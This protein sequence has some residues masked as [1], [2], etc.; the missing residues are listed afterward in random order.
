MDMSENK[1]PR[2]GAIGILGGGQLGRMLCVAAAQLG[3]RT[4]IFAPTTPCPAGDV[5]TRTIEGEYD[6]HDALSEFVSCTDVI[7]YEFENVPARTVSD[8]TQLGAIVRP[9]GRALEKAQDRLLE[10]DFVVSLGGATAPYRAVDSL[11]DLQDGLRAV[12]RPAILKTRRLGYDGKGQTRITDEPDEALPEAFERATEHAW[13][14]VGAAPSIIEG[15]VPFVMEISIIGARSANGDI[16][17]Y[18]PPRNEHHNGILRRSTA[19]AVVAD[20]TLERAQTITR[21]ML[22]ALEYVGVIGVEFFVLETGDVLVN[23]FAPRSDIPSIRQTRHGSAG[24]DPGLHAHAKPRRLAAGRSRG[25]R[26]RPELQHLRPDRPHGHDAEQGR[27]VSPFR[28]ERLLVVALAADGPR[29]PRAALPDH[30]GHPLLA[31]LRDRR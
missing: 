9:G 28:L 14:E 27:R 1:V 30:P 15:F 18:D 25:G 4:V 2:G 3:F 26:C 13:R 29:L 5:A 21:K 12:G 20:E 24:R 7:T 17:L 6:N 16:A 23:E 31:H 10:K 19:P 11:K 8:L 22:E